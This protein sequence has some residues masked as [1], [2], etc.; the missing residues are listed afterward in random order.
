MGETIPTTFGHE[1]NFLT[2]AQHAAAMRV[3]EDAKILSLMRKPF[4]IVPDSPEIREIEAIITEESLS[5][6]EP[7]FPEIRWAMVM[8]GAFEASKERVL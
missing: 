7:L 5:L 1:M 3:V 4:P 8:R 2:D 6:E